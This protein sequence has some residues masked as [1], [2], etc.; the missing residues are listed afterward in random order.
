ML[1]SRYDW[2]MAKSRAAWFTFCPGMD[3]I[4]ICFGKEL[5]GASG[6]QTAFLNGDFSLLNVP[7]PGLSRRGWAAGLG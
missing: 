1:E 2:V 5:H 7:N 3:Q 6:E 4:W